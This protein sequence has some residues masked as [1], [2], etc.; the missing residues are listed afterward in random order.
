MAQIV[1][2]FRMRFADERSLLE[3]VRGKPVYLGLAM[4][5]GKRVKMKPQNLL[6]N[7]PVVQV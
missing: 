4:T 7:L 5:T 2:L 6:A 3:R 1:G